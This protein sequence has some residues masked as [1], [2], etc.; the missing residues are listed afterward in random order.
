MTPKR[1]A[2]CAMLFAAGLAFSLAAHAQDYPAKLVKVIVPVPPGGGPDV[3]AR[4]LVERLADKWGQPV[5]VENR[6]GAAGNIGLEAASKAAPDGYT[7]VFAHQPPLVINKSLYKKLSYDPDAFAPISVV[8]AVPMV[9][10]VHPKVPV[11]NVQQLIDYA[12]AN[13]D[14]LNYAS[15]GSGSTPHLAVEFFKSRT[16]ARIVHVPY[17]GNAPAVGDLLGG[18]VD[19]MML[20]L[21][22]VLQHI[23]SGKLRG[24]AVLTERRN[25]ALPDVPAMA[26]LL[27]GFV[28][29]PWWGMVAPPKTPAAITEKVSATV[30]EALKRPDVAK[31]LAEMGNLAAVGST[32]AEMAQ[33]LKLERER[34]GNLIRAIGATAD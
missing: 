6:V 22:S 19:L 21:G 17:K 24:L 15:A 30:A 16:G 1:I 3:F 18:Q 7:L 31:R 25:P 9:A 8:V 33:F 4:M 11:Q 27:A 34:W 10:V 32:P 20:D 13:P 2:F 29:S 23:R 12:K 28:V 14:R 5:I 26:E